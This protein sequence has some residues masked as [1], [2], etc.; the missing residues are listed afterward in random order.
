MFF[1]DDKI[2]FL[3]ENRMSGVI[4]EP[5]PARK[6][7][8][9]WYKKLGMYTTSEED[10]MEMPT[11]KRCPPFLDAMTAGW[12]IPFPADTTFL[13]KDDGAGINWKS[14]FF[15]DTISNHN[16]KQI[17]THPNVPTVPVKVLNYW[18]IKTPPGW[19]CLFTPPLNRPDD[20]F[21]LMS[22]IVDTDKEFWEYIN[23]PGF[24]KA[25]EGT[26][27]IKQGH[28]M[29]Q[30]IPFKRNFNKDAIVRTLNKKEIAKMEKH[31]AK[32][33]ARFG[34]YRDSM[35]EKK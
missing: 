16:L 30:V 4:P 26:F 10:E 2:K 20:Y 25:K 22:G 1:G 8:P 19:S 33:S 27:T 3:C 13:V 31:R 17:L 21:D 6:F 5:Y 29:M 35:W 7:I 32:Q 18:V 23:F 28:P 9:D 15:C 14:T 12:I 11:L 34:Q 24:L